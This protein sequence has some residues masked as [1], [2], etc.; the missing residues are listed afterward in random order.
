M[1]KRQSGYQAGQTYTFD[2]TSS[3]IYKVGNEWRMGGFTD[4]QNMRNV[5]SSSNSQG[6]ISNGLYNN[7][8]YI[9]ISIPY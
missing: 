6:Y 2:S 5:A 9:T 1:Y 8:K 4:L 3:N 7:P